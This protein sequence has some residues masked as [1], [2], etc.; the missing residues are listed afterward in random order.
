MNRVLIVEDDAIC[1]LNLKALFSRA[2]YSVVKTVR[3]G[4]QA[5][6]S[7]ITDKPDFILMDI[8]LSDDVDGLT[9]SEKIRKTLDIP[10]VFITASTDSSNL[11]RLDEQPHCGIIKKPFDSNTVVQDVQTF[12][13]IN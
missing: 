6:H 13:N 4:K 1:A 7:A 8:M 5:I 2:G 11:K 9:A 10:I 3:T 12:L